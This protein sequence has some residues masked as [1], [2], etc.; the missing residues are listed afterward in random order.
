MAIKLV[1]QPKD[2]DGFN[3]TRIL[4]HQN[5]K[6]VGPFIFLDHMGP[7]QFAPGN[8]IDVRPHPH[9]GLATIT[10]ILEGSLLHRD[11]LGNNIEILPGD[12]NWMTAGSGI[13]HSERE[14]FEVKSIQHRLEGIQCWLAL[15][16]EQAEIEPSFSHI[17]RCQL[18]HYMKRNVH[19]RMIAGEAFNMTS[20]IRTYSPMFY[21]DILAGKNEE[22]RRPNPHQEC[23]VYLLNGEINIDGVQY[24]RGDFVLLEEEQYIDVVTNTRCLMFGGDKWLKT[25]HMYWNFVSFSKQRIEQAKTDWLAQNFPSIPDDNAEF[26]PLPGK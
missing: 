8:G 13:V 9:I 14:T 11:S 3:V 16:K 5:K 10:Y 12:I 21:L 15:P 6:M 20:P 25:P 23:A 1:G 26:T 19:Y 24:Q 22:I 7:A 17:K 18:P 2:L 4:P